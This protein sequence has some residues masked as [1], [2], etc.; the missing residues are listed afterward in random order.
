MTSQRQRDEFLWVLYVWR[1]KSLFQA[2]T[3][4]RRAE[5]LAMHYS[6]SRQKLGIVVVAAVVLI[7]LGVGAV[8]TRTVVPAAKVVLFYLGDGIAAGIM[9]ALITHIRRATIIYLCLAGFLFT[10][11]P[12]FSRMPIYWLV[13][14]RVWESLPESGVTFLGFVPA[15]AYITGLVAAFSLAGYH[16]ADPTPDAQE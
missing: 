15:I 4:A 13:P 3:P 12:L 2:G 5:L 9:L 14:D 11:Q 6:W 1:V 8:L 7:A 10:F 16:A